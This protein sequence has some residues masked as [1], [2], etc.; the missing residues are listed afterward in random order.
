MAKRQTVD[1]RWSKTAEAVARV[2]V[3]QGYIEG[4]EKTEDGMTLKLKYQG[5]QAALADIGRVSTPGARV[6]VGYKEIPRVW[7]GV[8]MVIMSTPA[9]V[10][11]DKAAR[12][13]KLGGEVIC[14]VR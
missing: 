4:V 1:V 11:A 5:R 10:M 7:G 3:T 2:L 9:G 12:K 8:G 6:Y 13:Q 14:F